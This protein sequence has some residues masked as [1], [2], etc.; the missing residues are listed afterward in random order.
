MFE[1]VRLEETAVRFVGL[2]DIFDLLLSGFPNTPWDFHLEVI[3]Q[4]SL[5]QHKEVNQAFV[6]PR[7]ILESTDSHLARR[8]KTHSTHVIDLCNAPGDSCRHIF[9]IGDNH[10]KFVHT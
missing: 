6:A 7:S 2:E 3:H 10:L 8:C 1:R 5:L 4:Q 9:C